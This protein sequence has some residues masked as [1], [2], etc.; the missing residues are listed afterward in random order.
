[1]SPLTGD[2]FDKMSNDNLLDLDAKPGKMTGG[3]MTYI[4]KL[5]MPFIFSN[6]NGTSSDVDTLTHV[7]LVKKLLISYLKELRI[8]LD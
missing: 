8:M 5:K 3:Y 2:F 4:P 1:M 7:D 6:S